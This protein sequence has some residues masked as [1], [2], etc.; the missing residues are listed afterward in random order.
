MTQL[1]IKTARYYY[2][3]EVRDWDLM[4]R[5]DYVYINFID[6]LITLVNCNVFSKPA[7]VVIRIRDRFRTILLAMIFRCRNNFLDD[8]RRMVFEVLAVAFGYDK[9]SGRSLMEL[10]SNDTTAAVSLLTYI[11]RCRDPDCL[12]AQSIFA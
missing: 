1:V 9:L 4:D 3:L 5:G 8:P 7:S 2:R 10:L 6:P 12:S 11:L